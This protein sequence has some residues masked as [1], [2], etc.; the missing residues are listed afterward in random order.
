M[1]QHRTRQ[2]PTRLTYCELL[3]DSA[4]SDE[5]ELIHFILLAYVDPISYKDTIKNGVWRR[6]TI[7]ELRSKEKNQT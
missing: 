6:T 5:V 7:N 1:L 2:V 4:V 3:L